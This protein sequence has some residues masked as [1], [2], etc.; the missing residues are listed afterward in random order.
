MRVPQRTTI[1]AAVFAL[2]LTADAGAQDALTRLGLA[3]PR[4]RELATGV[5]TGRTLPLYVDESIK[6][7]FKAMP[8]SLRASVTTGTWAW[9]RTYVGS[10]AF[11]TEY[12]RI[13]TEARPEAPKSAGTPA[14]ELKKFLDEQAKSI[15]D[16][17]KTIAT[18][19]ADQ[20]A[21]METQ[22]KQQEEMMKGREFQDVMRTSFEQQ[23][24]G[25][26]AEHER[27][28][29]RWE[30]EWPADS[31]KLVATRL[32]EFLAACADVDFGART[33]LVD[34]LARFVNQAYERKSSEWKACYRAGREPTEAARR[35]AT[36]W[37]AAIGG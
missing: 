13:R 37:L 35:A 4:A 17:R 24:A 2:V 3:E 27:R 21:A 29:K 28:V 33:Q 16:V 32:R 20:R 6:R 11:K 14:E 23:R 31:Q 34:G 36:S 19:P 18:L 12:A 10:A 26:I 25:A 5:A 15:A 8:A 22:I 9:A 1:A 7:A 30:E